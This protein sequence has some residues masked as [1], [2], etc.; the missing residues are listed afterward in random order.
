MFGALGGFVH[1]DLDYDAITSTFAFDGGQVEGYA[2]YLR[3]GLFVAASSSTPW[4][5]CICSGL[6][7]RTFGFPN[8]VN[9]TTVGV[10]TDLGYRF[11]SFKHGA[12]IEPLATI[13]I[14]WA[15]IDGF[16]LGGNTVSFGDDPNVRGGWGLGPAPQRQFGPGSLWGRLSSGACG[17]TSPKTM[18]RRW[19]RGQ[20][21]RCV[22]G[23]FG[24]R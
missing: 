23:G 9:V 17:A 5:T 11:G 15:D 13:S 20:S 10:R 19:Y 1:A 14:N 21:R 16:S 22:G 4:S 2:T 6:G 12:F 8:S 7:I 18:K 3:G 24:R